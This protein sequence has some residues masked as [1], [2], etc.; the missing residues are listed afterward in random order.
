[1]DTKK[2]VIFDISEI[3]D[4][5]FNEVLQSNKDSLRVS[6]DYKTIIKYEGEMPQSIKSLLTKS[7]E[8]NYEQILVILNQDNWKINNSISGETLN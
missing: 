2:Y 5:D 1:M 6:N 8:Y 4:I 7:E 3:D